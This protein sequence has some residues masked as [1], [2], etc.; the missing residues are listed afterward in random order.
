M[1]KFASL[2]LVLVL[3]LAASTAMADKVAVI[4]DPIGTN[5]FLTQVQDKALEMQETYG[6]ELS[7]M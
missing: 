2:I 1:K 6:Y 4:C 3:A 5:L 7:I